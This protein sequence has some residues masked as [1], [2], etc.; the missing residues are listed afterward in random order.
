MGTEPYEELETESLSQWELMWRQFRR[1]RLAMA[2]SVVLILFYLV[3]LS[4]GFVATQDPVQRNAKYAY[5]PPQL[6]KFIDAEGK[7][8]MRPFVYGL[9]QETDPDTW[10]KVYVVDHTVQHPL[11]LFVRGT[12]YKWFGL[13]QSN[14]HLFGV[15]GNAPFFLLGTDA[16]GRDMFSRIIHGAQISLS[17][18]LIGVFISLILGLAIGGL[19]GLLGGTVDIVIQRL[20]EFLIS[21]PHIPFWMALSAALPASW[22]AIKTYFAI[23]VLLSLLSWTEV[24]RVVRGKFLSLRETDFVAASISMGG[25][26]WWVIFKHLIPNFLSYVLVTV[27]LTIPGMILGETS[28]SFL[29]IGLRPPAI[30]WGVLLQQAQNMRTVALRPWLLLPGLFVVIAVLAFNFVGDGLRDAADPYAD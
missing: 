13:F 14:V 17:I 12:P 8:H 18:G 29:G 30:S 7:F 16:L 21:I 27:S 9:T 6:P 20:I 28:L 11:K 15:E 24:A 1:H 10:E 26:N 19:S 3:A 5:T 22:S 2:G 23:T 4:A 25:S